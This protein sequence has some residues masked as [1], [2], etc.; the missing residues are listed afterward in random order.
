MFWECD[1][2][3]R[4]EDGRPFFYADS[5]RHI[6]SPDPSQYLQYLAPKQTATEFI[7]DQW[8]SLVE[9]YTSRKLTKANDVFPALSGVVGEIVKLLADDYLAGL[10]RSKLHVG[11]LWQA[12]GK[13]WKPLPRPPY[14]HAPSWSWAAVNGP[15]SYLSSSVIRH[16][17]ETFSDIIIHE[18][19]CDVLG[20]NSYGEVKEGII[21]LTGLIKAAIL[22]EGTQPEIPGIEIQTSDGI[23]V[24]TGYMD[25]DEPPQKQVFVLK[26]CRSSDR[27]EAGA[28][29]FALLL[30]HVVGKM[31]TYERVGMGKVTLFD[32]FDNSK[33]ETIS[34]I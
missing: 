14:H 29:W 6:L 18:T 20:Q 19:R 10:W 13:N 28:F 31:E 9:N 30:R 17:A 2:I 11:L 33:L 1:E 8:Y 34:I 27:T 26:V 24:G 3:T 7:Y 15:I 32:W 16:T 12:K 25:T 5:L 4:S 22:D 23:L 21:R